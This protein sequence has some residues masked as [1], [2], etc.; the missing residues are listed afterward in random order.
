MKET[1]ISIAVGVVIMAAVI[2]GLVG[3]KACA[4]SGDAD[5]WN[6]G[7]CSECGGDYV[8]SSATSVRGWGDEYFYTCEDC[9][10][11]IKTQQLMR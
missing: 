2:F 9:G 5:K 11:T 1:V 6:N 4:G 10:H 3:M 8:F 7:H